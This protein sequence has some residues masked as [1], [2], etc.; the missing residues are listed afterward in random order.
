MT[1]LNL[2]QMGEILKKDLIDQRAYNDNVGIRIQCTNPDVTGARVT[3]QLSGADYQFYAE[4]DSGSGYADDSDFHG[5]G[6]ADGYFTVTG[7][8]LNNVV[9]FINNLD[10]WTAEL[11]NMRPLASANNLIQKGPVA[12]LNADADF[13]LL[14]AAGSSLDNKITGTLVQPGDGKAVKFTKLEHNMALA[15]AGGA[16]DLI[17]IRDYDPIEGTETTVFTATLVDGSSTA[18]SYEFDYTFEVG[19]WMHVEFQSTNAF[20]S[21]GENT[22]YEEQM[23]S[24]ATS[25]PFTSGQDAGTAGY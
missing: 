24:L 4:T 10:N 25:T 17:V 8:T 16:S 5:V 7:Y 2:L 3:F 23:K 9:S 18:Q 15:G 21:G 20:S 12:C 22:Y 1:D 14:A 11:V 13:A 6:E 19:H